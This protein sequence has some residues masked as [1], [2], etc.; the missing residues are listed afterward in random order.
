MCVDDIPLARRLN[1]K[2]AHHSHFCIFILLWFHWSAS[3]L[4]S[5]QS[6]QP[7]ID[8]NATFGFRIPQFHMILC[9]KKSKYVRPKKICPSA[10]PITC[11]D[12]HCQYLNQVNKHWANNEAEQKAAFIFR[13]FNESNPSTHFFSCPCSSLFMRDRR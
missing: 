8:F 12:K 2:G 13:Q 6:S 11:W 1:G 4:T 10:R 9:G 3:P 7:T 5:I